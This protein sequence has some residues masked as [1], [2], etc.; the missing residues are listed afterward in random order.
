MPEYK[1]ICFTSFNMDIDWKELNI[2]QIDKKQSIKYIIYQGEHCKDGKKHI[3]GFLQLHKKKEF[4]FI[5]KL[6][7]DKTLHIENMK[8]TPEQ[9][10]HYCTNEYKDKDGNHK[11]IWLE[12]IEYGEI[13]HTNQGKRT[14]L[15][16]LK[17]K[18][19][20]GQSLTTI[21]KNSDDNKEIHNILQYG[22]GL[23]E[24]QQIVQQD[25]V[26]EDLIQEYKDVEWK[27][28]QQDIL[29]IIKD[30]PDGRTINWIWEEKGNIGKSYIGD[31]IV[32]NH[33]A[34]HIT[35][36]K[37]ADILYA[38]EG[39]ET[40]IIDLPRDETKEKEQQKY[41]YNVIETLLGRVYLNT[42]YQSKMM[43]KPKT[44]ILIFANNPP[45]QSQLSQDRWNIVDLNSIED[46]P[47]DISKAP[48]FR[49]YL[50]SKYNA[51]YDSST[52]EEDE[53]LP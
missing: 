27:P 2:E 11:S 5:K 22:K 9:A 47:C 41:I 39:Q 13:D 20:E 50:K 14:D 46:E 19:I 12:Q 48:T 26:K 49:K 35:G 34:F 4:T 29:D 52:E 23:K 51:I 3:Q 44:H 25:K 18:I 33:N 24:L 42:K 6:I 7:G 31:Y 40:I 43:Y 15:L 38:Y 17:T 45:D 30:K 8:G 36:G 10:R 37:K 32:S 16:E 53:Y 1:N 28:F 21:L